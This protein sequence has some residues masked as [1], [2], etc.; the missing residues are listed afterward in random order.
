MISTLTPNQSSAARFFGVANAAA[1]AMAARVAPSGVISI[2]GLHLGLSTPVSATFN[3]S[4]FLPIT[5]GGIRV[6]IG[7][8]AAPLLYVSD[9]Q[10]NTV[11]PAEP[12]VYE[13]ESS[14][15]LSGFS[16]HLAFNGSG[17][18]P[19]VRVIH[20]NEGKCM[21]STC[22][23]LLILPALMSAQDGATIYHDNCASCHDMPAG[24]VPPRSAIKAMSPEVIY[25][26]LTKGDMKAQAKGLSTAQIIALIR[27]IAP[28]GR[29]V[30]APLFPPTC[31]AGATLRFSV[32]LPQWNGWS[33]DV[34]NRRFQ[35]AGQAGIAT[36]AVPRLK[37]KW[38]FN[39]GNV[40]VARSQPTIVAGRLFI[41]TQTGAVYALDADTG[42]T[43][44]GFQAAAA[45]R[46]GAAFGEANRAPAIFFSDAGA[47][48]YAVNAQ[49]GT[50]IWKVR[51]VDHIAALATATPRFYKGVLYQ[52][53]AS[54][55]E[56]PSVDPKYP[57]CTFRGSVVAL[58]A[59]T[60]KTIWQAFTIPEAPKAT[61]KNPAGTVEYGPSGAGVWSTPTI[62]E[63][64]GVLYVATGDN[65]SE[66]A[67][68]TSDAVLA[69]DL[70][71]GKL[72]W[73]TQLRSDDVFNDSCA[74]PGKANCQHPAGPDYDFGQSP[75][76]VS[77]S[78]AKRALVVAQKSGM[79]YALDPDRQG[80]LIW[81]AR[82]GEGGPFGGSQW[83]SAS[84]G[85]KVY[86][87]IS[88][89]GVKAVA[90]PESPHRFRFVL[91]PQKGGGLNAFGLKTGKLVWNVR[92]A[93][94]AASKTNCSPAQSAAVTA[95]PGV[96][97]SGSV[98]GHLRAYSTATGDVL[99][100]TDT[101]GE[102]RTVNG[103]VAH[104]GSMD[105]AGVVVVNGLVFANS[106]FNQWGGMPG[107]V[108]LAFSVDGK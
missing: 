63:Q 82:A 25:V 59:A 45:I 53:F 40:S 99:W 48:V 84:D 21:R 102:F 67:T 68:S 86:V 106:G 51:P 2:Y 98:D 43:H 10:I 70:K 27:Y 32:D 44:W 87:A 24:R 12:R 47:N 26:A 52:P 103:G 30:V 76:L 100:D 85:Q 6:I 49:T 58:D 62:D 46:S 54:S 22:L 20:I 17:F 34:M 11:A 39:L 96:V 42:C 13:T 19:Q 104:G 90:D 37:L 38:A 29:K 77:L 1:G 88:D 3:S 15:A 66:P 83:G 61:G 64:L 89:Q 101:A 65:Y 93:P 92:A 78:E 73:S 9:T 41:G 57:C 79:V 97:F 36:A 72:L 4:G 31:Q 105:V 71:T 5:L 81:Q 33:P 7:G 35:D 50:M 55:E 56:G 74:T 14:N 69:I 18:R 75:I 108:L 107:N 16:I 91:D 94:C 28:T 95:I 23:L 80:K 60:G 8:I